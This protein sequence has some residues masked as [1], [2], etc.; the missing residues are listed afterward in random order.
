MHEETLI[1]IAI[2]LFLFFDDGKQKEK[3]LEEKGGCT[4]S[5]NKKLGEHKASATTS[6]EGFVWVMRILFQ[7]NEINVP[8]HT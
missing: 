8:D 5:F 4:R 2:I 3:L 1:A 7:V 6:L